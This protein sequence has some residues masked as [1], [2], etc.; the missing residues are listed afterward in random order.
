MNGNIS[1]SSCGDGNY[2]LFYS[3]FHSRVF[4]AKEKE[5]EFTRK[6]LGYLG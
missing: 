5:N 1:Q 6:G 4:V 3:F 2:L